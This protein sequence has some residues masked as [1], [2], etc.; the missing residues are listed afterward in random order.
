[1]DVFEA[2]QKRK[3]VRDYKHTPVPKKKLKKIL[4]AARLAPS[5]NNS[6]PWHF[7][8]VTDLAKK[9]ALSKGI[10]AKWLYHAPVVIVACGDPEASPDWYAVDVSLALENMVLAATGEGLATCYVGSFDENDVK[11]LLGVPEQLSVIALLAVGYAVERGETTSKVDRV[12]SSR[13]KRLQDIVSM[14][15]FGRRMESKH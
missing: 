11:A 3:S 9:K 15:E 13:R 1:M 5:A 8:I 4:K 10:F 12:A 14:E 7:I 6:Q 2:I